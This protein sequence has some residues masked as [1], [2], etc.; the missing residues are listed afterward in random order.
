MIKAAICDDEVYFVNELHCLIRK[1]FSE[2]HREIRITDFTT[3]GPLIKHSRD[4]DLIFLD[5]QMNDLNGFKTAE[6]LRKNGF[7][8][9]LVFVTIMK[10]EVYKAFEYNAFDYLLKPLDEK[11]LRHTAKRFLSSFNNLEKTLVVDKRNERRLIKTV[12]ILYCEIINRKVELHLLNGE[13]IEYYE[14]ISELETKLGSEFY[15]AHRSY[16]V[17]LRY[18]SACSSN[19]ITLENGAKIPLSRNRKT[20]LMNAL[21]D[22]IGEVE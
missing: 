4:F 12:E 3:G 1:I 15:K 2:H 8:G 11:H 17:N 14:K 21:I 16:L 7:S 9:C 18:I 6:L 5:V 19:E 13:V 10:N 20:G 22:D